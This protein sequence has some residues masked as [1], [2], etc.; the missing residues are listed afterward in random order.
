MKIKSTTVK[1]RQRGGE[2]N[3]RSSHPTSTSMTRSG[4][5]GKR[6]RNTRPGTRTN[7]P[8]TGGGKAPSKGNPLLIIGLA[9][10]FGIFLLV[11]IIVAVSGKREEPVRQPKSVSSGSKRKPTASTP[12]GEYGAKYATY[13]PNMT[14][15]EESKMAKD[16]KKRRAQKNR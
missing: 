8:Y 4:S 9:A 7:N 6:Q 5:D 15:T 12:R 11:I 1:A 3:R 13:D 2:G 16:R 14:M 10:G